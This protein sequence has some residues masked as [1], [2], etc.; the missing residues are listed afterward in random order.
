MV[1]LV[2]LLMVLAGSVQEALAQRLP[3]RA[4]STADGLA[5]DAI[6]ALL[7]DSR[8]FL[9]VGTF[10]GLSRFDGREFRTFGAADGLPHPMVNALLEDRD[11]VIWVATRAGLAR[12][13]P[14]GRAMSP[15]N[16]G[17]AT[18]HNIRHVLQTKDGRVVAADKNNLYIFAN[19]R[20]RRSPTRIPVAFPTQPPP[21]LE[22]FSGIEALTEGT[23]GD[24]WIGTS[25]GLVRRLRDGRM[26]PIRVRPTD[27][28]DRIY[29]VA[30]DHA[31]RVWITHWGNAHRPHVHFGVYVLMP[32]SFTAAP[33]TLTVSSSSS[34]S[35]SPS[36]SPPR[37]PLQVRARL[38]EDARDPNTVPLPTR[39]DEAIYMTAGGP[40]GDARPHITHIAAD[41]TIWI[42]SEGGVLRIDTTD[43]GGHVTRFSERNGL[44]MPIY[45]VAT[46]ARGDMWLGA[47]GQGLLRLEMDGFLTYA[48]RDGLPRGEVE[49]IVEDR[50]G[51]LCLTG[52]DAANGSQWFGTFDPDG[53]PTPDGGR[54]LRFMPRGTEHLH[55]WGWGWRQL[56]LQDHTGEWWVPTGEGLF[57]Y[58]ASPS[59]TSMAKTP[60]KAI[61]TKRNG[62]PDDDIFRLFED[63]RGDLWLSCGQFVVRWIRETDTF[64][65]VD[66]RPNSPT[67]FIEDAGHNIWIGFYRGG[68]GRW[69]RGADG[70]TGTLQLFEGRDG[71][72]DGFVHLVYVDSRGRLWIGT[73]PGGLALIETPTA[74]QPRVVPLPR[75]AAFASVGVA[76]VIEDPQRRLYIG[77]YR[78]LVRFDAALAHART[79]S[80]TDITSNGQHTGLVD[81][82]GRV[83][84]GTGLGL[85]RLDPRPDGQPLPPTIFID[86]LRIGGVPQPLSLL[87][88]QKVDGLTVDSESR[89]IEIG[90]GS[91]SLA[92]GETRR[93]QARLQGIDPDWGVETTNRTALYLNLAPGSY[94]FEARAVDADGVVSKQRAVVTFTILPPFWQR[95]W[96]RLLIGLIVLIA[97]Y[98]AY[99]SRV[100]HLLALERMRSRIAT[101]LHDDLG[102]RLSRISI[103][104]EVAARR[105]S[106]DA[107][108]AERLLGEVG[109]TAR[110]LIEATADI[111]WS[112]DPK[113]DDLGSLAA[114]IRRFAADMLDA[115]DIVWTLDAPEDGA[116]KLSPECR[117]HVLLVFQEAINNIV[118]HA[119]ARHV[120]LQLRVD[121]MRLEA[122][123]HDDGRGFD[124]A[125]REAGGNGGNGSS[126]NNG[127][128]PSDGYGLSNMASRA[129]ALGGTLT[130]TSEAGRG[131]GVHLMVP[132]R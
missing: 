90:Y 50:T 27:K 55:Y 89:R 107:T 42:P 92:P 85:H 45:T 5:G 8:G 49:G 63:S 96:F 15:V 25:W 100:R 78:G 122:E 19:E 128:S 66:H 106:S 10:T 104:S 18:T 132:I 13:E 95:A 94:R 23:D 21:S 47:R 61:Y 91:P 124:A 70:R 114:R 6:S 30:V 123:I 83:W 101:D 43:R 34:P 105:V 97:I 36:P 72:P 46:D 37:E 1:L 130:V 26:I 131:T 40:L 126:G 7:P 75:D 28:D 33:H 44:T 82:H 88:T 38:I 110:S 12:I 120:S 69:R 3:L 14:Q 16:L 52:N 51:A 71:V 29:D 119:H 112:V 125:K 115:R 116:I 109:E 81:R 24:L 48:A 118:R 103:L 102:A 129:R 65:I 76:S 59:C 4:Y 60:P 31:G 9:W 17:D 54:L 87:G 58:P 57:R 93:Y 68:V 41:G 11:G 22:Q 80:T 2:I 127:A 62:L 86:S 73:N 64:E 108:S 121:G 67:A 20:D 113:Q 53:D 32:E 98:L 35:P 99:R 84:I 117:R 77:S 56:F 39:P 74:D 79:F 111:T